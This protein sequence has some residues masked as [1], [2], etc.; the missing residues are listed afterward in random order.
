MR[1]TVILLLAVVLILLVGFYLRVHRLLDYPLYTDEVID[2]EIAQ[3][4]L[5]GDFSLR[6]HWGAG[7]EP[8]F[9]VAQAASALALGDNA[10]ALRW[11]AVLFGMALIP[12]VYVWAAWL[13]RSRLAAL[14]AAG[15]TGALW[16]PVL[17][18]RLSIRSI[19]LAVCIV[20]ALLGLWRGLYGS[21]AR[22]RRNFVLG[23]L[24]AG[25]TQYTFTAALGFPVAL[26]VFLAYLWLADRSTWRARWRGIALY[27]LVAAVVAGPFLLYEY[28]SPDLAWRIPMVNQPLEALRAGDPAPLLDGMLK[29]LGMF[30]G[31][32]DHVWFYNLPG[33]PVF[34]PPALALFLAGVLLCAWWAL[35]PG[36]HRERAAAGALLLLLGF[37]MLTPSAATDAPPSTHRAIG[38]L[39]AVLVIAVVPLAALERAFPRGRRWLALSAAAVVAFSGAMVA[40]D[41]FGV[42]IDH[43]DQVWMNYRWYA[44]MADFI[45][46]ADRT[47]GGAAFIFNDY[48]GF[49]YLKWRQLERQIFRDSVTLRRTFG[50]D[51]IVIPETGELLYYAHQA[52]AAPAEP[53]RRLFL[54]E[55]IRASAALDSRGMPVLTVYQANR[56]EALR[57]L[58]ALAPVYAPDRETRLSAPVDFDGALELLGVEFLPTTGDQITLLSYWRVKQRP[59]FVSIF[60]HALGADGEL[61]AQYDGLAP[62]EFELTPGDVIAQLHT[63]ALPAGRPVDAT[64][65]LTLGVYTEGDVIRLPVAGGVAD[66]VWLG[67]WPDQA[68]ASADTSPSAQ[69]WIASQPR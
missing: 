44:E 35:R 43:P 55:P 45:D 53:L 28:T 12:L 58:E 56:G 21:P 19:T 23:G 14:A 8:L 37:I 50:G 60:V 38:A 18:S 59:P 25:L 33:R 54:G 9:N 17:F 16:W 63:L 66:H 47:P 24:A 36:S 6:Y 65:N 20:L 62:A 49:D 22:A 2:G 61:V 7:R 57:R 11:P 40:R 32:G 64:Y 51:G 29:T 27:A 34:E 3:A 68:S 31:P 67:V 52:D 41:F 13:L 26:L 15:L 46:H 48:A 30:W 39:P 4:M 1:R 10:L 5:K 69:A 42:W